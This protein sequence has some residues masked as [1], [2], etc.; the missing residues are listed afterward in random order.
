M[1]AAQ[2]AEPV[3]HDS[4]PN[5]TRV[6]TDMDYAKSAVQSCLDN[7]NVRVD[8]HGLKYWAGRVESLRAQAASILAVIA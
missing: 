2:V 7:P 5:L 4:I 3:A 6:L 1:S 8:M